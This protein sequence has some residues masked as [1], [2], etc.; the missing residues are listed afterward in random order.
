MTQPLVYLLSLVVSYLL[1][2]IPFGY[3]VAKSRGV[4]IREVGSGNIG[5]TN[6]FRSVGKPAGL[7]TFILDAAKGFCS[8]FAIPLTAA[9]VAPETW[10]ELLAVGCA[11]FV[12]A[13]HNWP[14]YLRFNGGK[15]V[16][17]SAGAVLGIV[18]LAL[19]IG[20]LAWILTL[21]VTRFV[22]VASMAA[23]VAVAVSTWLMHADDSLVKPVALTCLC[24]VAIWR[25]KSNIKRLLNDKEP[26]VGSKQKRSCAT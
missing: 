2:A 4:N 11:A 3:I 13:G 23:A 17:T 21:F 8:S 14:I 10:T 9:H 7:L 5:A 20:L 1:G 26:R 25:H 24:A 22:S 16:A 19:A 15:G 6:V 18:P 12:V